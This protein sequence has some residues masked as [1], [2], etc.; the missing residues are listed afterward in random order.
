MVKYETFNLCYM[1][2]T[3]IGLS[4]EDNASFYYFLLIKNEFK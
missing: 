3:L 2:S 1:S 4:L